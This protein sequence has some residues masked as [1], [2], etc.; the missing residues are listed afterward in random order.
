MLKINSREKRVSL[1]D[2]L[3]I[4]PIV[5][6]TAF[7]AFY[8]L[9]ALLYPGG[10]QAYPNALSYSWEHN[11]FCTLLNETAINGQANKGQIFAIMSLIFLAISMANF[12]WTFPKQYS[13]SKLLSKLI[14]YTGL[15]SMG[16]A[17]LLLTNLDHDFITNLASVFGLIATI[18]TILALYQLKKQGLFVFGLLNLLL[19]VLNNWFYYHADLIVYLPLIQKISFASVLIWVIAINLTCYFTNTKKIN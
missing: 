7:L 15:I 17:C 10:S 13:L 19:V 2:F 4:I 14:Q 3:L 16:F 18:G 12:Y 8:I 9:A 5:G 6:I 1:K 11:F